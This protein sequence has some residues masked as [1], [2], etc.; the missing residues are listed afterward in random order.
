MS[1]RRALYVFLALCAFSS[2]AMA[3]PI[4]TTNGGFETG[5]FTG[6]STLGDALVVNS[7]FGV[8]PPGGSFQALISN[9]PGYSSE[10]DVPN[11]GYPFQGGGLGFGGT[12]SG[13]FSSSARFGLESFLGLPS[14]SLDSFCGT[15][16]CAFTGSAIKQ[17]FTANAGDVISFDFDYLS[18]DPAIDFGFVVVD[19][20]ASVLSNASSGCT[21]YQRVTFTSETPYV[22]G[23]L[24]SPTGFSVDCGYQLFSTTVQGS[25]THY[26]GAGVVHGDGDFI[27][28]SAILVDNVT[29]NGTPSAVPEPG[30]WMLLG[31]GLCLLAGLKRIRAKRRPPS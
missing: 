15:T 3:D 19:G 29:L 30:T 31:S 10:P 17:S 23:S 1:I 18:N 6:W 26:I 11:P 21:T 8:T 14:G 25:G 5:D 2:F 7:S 22:W 27:A 24:V 28:L 12:Y 13:H 4:L 20:T 16:F 9:A